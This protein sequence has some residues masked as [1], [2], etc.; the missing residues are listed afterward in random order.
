MTWHEIHDTVG[1]PVWF[2][3][4]H[5]NLGYIVRRGDGKWDVMR[6]ADNP[7]GAMSRHDTADEAKAAYEAL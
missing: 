5:D 4:D 7:K 6:P 2:P 1:R 3:V